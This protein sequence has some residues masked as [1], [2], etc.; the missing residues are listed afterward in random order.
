MVTLPR[1]FEPQIANHAAFMAREP[2][3]KNAMVDIASL[4]GNS[5][6]SFKQRRATASKVRI[7][8]VLTSFL[9]G[10]LDRCCRGQQFTP[11]IQQQS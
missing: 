10:A 3:P 5:L 4:A 7:P 8:R 2:I 9:D 6:K 1:L 11:D